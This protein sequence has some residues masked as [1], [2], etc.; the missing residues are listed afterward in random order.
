LLFK[1]RKKFQRLEEK[2]R[3]KTPDTGFDLD[4]DKY[5]RERK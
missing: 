1:K 4:S 3:L 5:C 2:N